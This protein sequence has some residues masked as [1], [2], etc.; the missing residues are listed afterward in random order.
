MNGVS[1]VGLVP[2]SMR[3]T[4]TQLCCDGLDAL[5]GYRSGTQSSE[6]HVDRVGCFGKP[7]MLPVR[8]PVFVLQKQ[9]LSWSNFF[10]YNFLQTAQKRAKVDITKLPYQ[11]CGQGGCVVS[12]TW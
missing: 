11:L 8:Y 7:A 6:R 12:D 4:V 3:R 2:Y 9:V 5:R 1:H 10:R